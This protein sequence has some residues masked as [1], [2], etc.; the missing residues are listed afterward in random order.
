MGKGVISILGAFAACVA[1]FG[2]AESEPPESDPVQTAA[3]L[4]ADDNAEPSEAV[5]IP[6]ANQVLGQEL[7]YG[8]AGNSN[9]NGYLAMPAGAT[10]PLPGVV[11]IH[12]W[13]GLNDNIR[14]MADRLAAEGFVVLAVDLYGGQS[15]TTP[16]E[17]QSLMGELNRT[18]EAAEANLRQAVEY[19]ELYALAPKVAVM[20][21]CLGGGYALSAGL[22]F[23]DQIDAVVMYYGRVEQDPAELAKLEAPLLGLF[24]GQDRGIPVEGVR[25]FRVALADLGKNAHIEVYPQADH[26]FA[27]PSG[28]NYNATA[29]EDA[30]AKTLEFLTGQ[31]DSA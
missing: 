2:C 27:N 4:H 26:A 7:A 9:L 24:G 30:W 17:A 11:M 13:W 29:A 21:W 25:A 10:E 20:G 12:E 15:A 1:L 5:A 23:G 18:P 22:W 14:A 16:E 19:L 3:E 6:P 8:E 31:L 28:R